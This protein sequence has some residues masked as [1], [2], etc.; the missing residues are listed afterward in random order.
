MK[1]VLALVLAL[2]VIVATVGT[3]SAADVKPWE[4]IRGMADVKPW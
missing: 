1:K 4:K 3:A 2:G